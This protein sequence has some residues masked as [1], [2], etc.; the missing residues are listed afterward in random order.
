MVIHPSIFPLTLAL[1]FP[2]LTW[3]STVDITLHPF[4]NDP[5]SFIYMILQR[6]EK[7]GSYP[8]ASKLLISATWLFSN[9]TYSDPIY[10]RPVYILSQHLDILMLYRYEQLWFHQMVGSPGC[11]GDGWNWGNCSP[12]FV[13]PHPRSPARSFMSNQWTKKWWFRLLH[14]TLLR[15]IMLRLPYY[16]SAAANQPLI[17]FLRKELVW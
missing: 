12:C 16:Q 9:T 6:C 14:V 13:A 15:Q 10:I 17:P 5:I 2:L 4:E 3:V 1:V 7:N 11:P 8:Q